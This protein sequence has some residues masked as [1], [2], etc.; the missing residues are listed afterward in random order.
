[1]STRTLTLTTRSNTPSLLSALCLFSVG[2]FLFGC[3]DH[4]SKN[5]I[6]D[7]TSHG[8]TVSS[9]SISG[10]WTGTSGS[11]HYST[12]VDVHDNGGD[13]SGSLRWSWGGVRSFSG[14]RNGNFIHWTTQRDSKGVSD[15]WNMTLSPD[16]RHLTGHANKTDG[17]GYDIS[18]SR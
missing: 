18:L 9:A 3:E 16:G 15:A 1:M 17:G 14:S 12:V 8:S 10:R 4:D 11:G 5:P 6:I 13:I 7:R 2:I